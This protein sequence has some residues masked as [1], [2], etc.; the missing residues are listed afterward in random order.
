MNSRLDKTNIYRQ[1]PSLV[2]NEL[3]MQEARLIVAISRIRKKPS[4]VSE[5]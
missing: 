4:T 5:S 2:V 1:T 3:H